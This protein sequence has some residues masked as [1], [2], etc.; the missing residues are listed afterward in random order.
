MTFEMT[1]R[2]NDKRIVALH[3]SMMDLMAV[4]G[5]YVMVLSV[6]VQCRLTFWCSLR[7]LAKEDRGSDGMT[8]GVR[9]KD[10]MQAIA[11]D[12]ET[13]AA[14]CDSFQ[15]KK[16]VGTSDHP[17]VLIVCLQDKQSRSS[18][19]SPGRVSWKASRKLLTA[20]KMRCTKTCRCIPR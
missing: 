5:L 8:I 16:L 15:K 12:I 6:L 14:K 13:C 18:R 7:N 19:V 17:C 4:I 1:R 3:V 9:L 2:Q 20:T 10:R 11:K